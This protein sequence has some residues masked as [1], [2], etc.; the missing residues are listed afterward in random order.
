[1]LIKDWL[2][3]ST[4]LLKYENTVHTVPQSSVQPWKSGD[5]APRKMIRIN[6]GFSP[7]GR[8]SR[9]QCFFFGSLLR[10][11]RGFGFSINNHQPKINNYFCAFG[12]AALSRDRRWIALYSNGL[13]ILDQNM[14]IQKRFNAIS[15]NA[16]FDPNRDFLYAID[17]TNNQIVAFDTN[18]WTEKYRLNLGFT[19]PNLPMG[20]ARILISPDSSTL[21]VLST[22]R[23][24]EYKIPL[25][26]GQPA[27]FGM[28]KAAASRSRPTANMPHPMSPPTA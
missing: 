7:C 6:A 16:V 15:G 28:S 9:W 27:T 17:S 11:L 22:N 26:T 8:P 4:T 12:P 13:V 25:P 19:N 23:L 10:L 18:N 14:V 21:W 5:S 2:K 20:T 3:N 1:L 24:C